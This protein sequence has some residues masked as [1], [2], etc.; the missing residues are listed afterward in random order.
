LPRRTP[1]TDDVH[2]PDNIAAADVVTSLAHGWRACRPAAD[3]FGLAATA[4]ALLTGAPPSGI[5]RAW[6]DI[7]PERANRLEQALRRGLAI[8]P[9]QRTSTPGELVEEPRTGWDVDRGGPV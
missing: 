7:D 2:E 1:S 3:V 8:D 5:L 6:G 4:F 9:T